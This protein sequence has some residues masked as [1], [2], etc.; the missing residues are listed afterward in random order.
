MRRT[1]WGLA[2][3]CAVGA[4]A[5]GGFWL[6]QSGLSQSLHLRARIPIVLDWASNAFSSGRSLSPQAS[7]TVLYY[8]DP[9]GR[10]AYALGPKRTTDGR[11]YVA[12]HAGEDVSFGDQPRDASKRET[13]AS[14]GSKRVLY[15]R[16]P[17]GLP[18]TSAVPKKDSMGMDYIPVY[19]GEDDDQGIVSVSSGKVQRTGVRSERVTRRVVARTIR[20]PATIQLDERRVSVVATR[21]ESFVD[22][23]ESV[24][25]GDRVKLGQPLI[26]LFSP[27]VN[28]AAAQLIATGIGYEGSRRRLRNLNVPDSAIAEMERTRTV[29]LAIQWTAPRDGIVLERNAVDGM[30]AGAGD[31]LFRIA[32]VSVVWALADVPEHVLDGLKVGDPVTVQL[33]A[34]KERRFAG[35]IS[36]VYPQVSM[37]TRTARVRIELPN[38]DA[39]LL[40]GMYAEAEVAVGDARPVVAVPDDAVIDNGTRRIVLVEKQEGRFEPREVQTGA[41]GGG[42]TEVRKGLGEGENVVTSANFLIDAESNLKSALRAMSDSTASA[43][44]KTQ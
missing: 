29:P 39:S 6:G 36:V 24:T 23:V 16:N 44:E 10:P 27:D 43:G 41:R 4:A 34:M 13:A 19:E 11:A 5:S 15:Y 3:L 40:P 14:A 42:Y 38:P 37:D 33:R 32:D 2:A 25:T 18:D 17:M 1:L 7:D 28:A 12:V 30:R 31:V 20:V 26:R 9:D 22:K 35:R 8:R 21:S